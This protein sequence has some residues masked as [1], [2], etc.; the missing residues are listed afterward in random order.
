M[1]CGASHFPF[2]KRRIEDSKIEDGL[3]ICILRLWHQSYSPTRSCR[4]Y[5]EVLSASSPIR[6]L[7]DFGVTSGL[8][9]IQPELFR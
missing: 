5:L 9:V 2:A 3:H 4:A 7:P 6:T 8:P 1:L